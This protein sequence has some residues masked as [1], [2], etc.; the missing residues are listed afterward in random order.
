MKS[1]LSLGIGSLQADVSACVLITAYS[2]EIDG[3]PRRDYDPSMTE[4][5]IN[6]DSGAAIFCV[7]VSAGG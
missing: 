2:T 6:V 5:V 1:G 7:L 4:S 3:K